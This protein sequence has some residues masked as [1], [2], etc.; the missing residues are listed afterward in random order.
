MLD[1]LARQGWVRRASD[2]ARPMYRRMRPWTGLSGLDRAVVPYL[3]TRPGV[4]VEAG[5]NDGLKQSNTHFLE[6][7]RGWHGLLIEP[8]PELAERCRRNRPRSQV[9]CA[10][11]VPPDMDGQEV[12]LVDVDLMS[13]LRPGDLTEEDEAHL[14]GGEQSQGV[15]RRVLRVPGKTLSGLL[16]DA[17]VQHV[18]FLSLDVEGFEVEALRGLDLSRHRPSWVLVESRRPDEVAAVLGPGYERVAQLSVHDWLFRGTAPL[19]VD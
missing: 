12:E 19:A 16:E 7:R 2:A 5:A 10:A 14:V 9:R 13:I 4:F 6:R 18:D 15:R 17:Q 1:A 3:P 11:L 8:I